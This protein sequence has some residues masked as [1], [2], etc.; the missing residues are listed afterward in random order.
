MTSTVCYLATGCSNPSTLILFLSFQVEKLTSVYRPKFFQHPEEK[1]LGIIPVRTPVPVSDPVVIH[2][3]G[4]FFS[5]AVLLMGTSGE[6]RGPF[7]YMVWHKQF[8]WAFLYAWNAV[9]YFLLCSPQMF[10]S[11]WMK[12]LFCL[13]IV[14]LIAM[15]L[16]IKHF[17]LVIIRVNKIHAEMGT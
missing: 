17:Q 9:W 15:W 14:K 1:F 10:L 7:L 13:P 16:V 3:T 6:Q 5:A 11:D 12:R 4:S 8:L 2:I